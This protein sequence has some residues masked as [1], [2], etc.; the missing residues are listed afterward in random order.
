MKA[1]ENKVECITGAFWC[2]APIPVVAIC[3]GFVFTP[4]RYYQNEIFGDIIPVAVYG[5]TGF[6]AAAATFLAA[7]ALLFPW[8]LQSFTFVSKLRI[9][10]I[11]SACGCCAA[12]YFGLKMMSHNE[13]PVY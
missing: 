6:F 9:A 11:I 12:V 10:L 8:R 5:F 13:P 2:S 4:A 7:L 1:T 3:V